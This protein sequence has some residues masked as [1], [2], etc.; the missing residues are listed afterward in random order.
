ML[1]EE[2]QVL[3]SH[4][5]G[6]SWIKQVKHIFFLWYYGN[7]Y[8]ILQSEIASFPDTFDHGLAG[9]LYIYICVYMYI[10]ICIHNIQTRNYHALKMFVNSLAHDA[11]FKGLNFCWFIIHLAFF[12]SLLNGFYLIVY[13]FSR[14]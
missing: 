13:V 5:F 14:D 8:Y 10:Y 12:P 6:T 2:R 9:I 7:I 1:K 11:D 4:K 3:R